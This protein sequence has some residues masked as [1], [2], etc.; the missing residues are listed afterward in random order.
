MSYQLSQE[1]EGDL[2]EIYDRSLDDWGEV[3]ADRYLEGLY[4][5]FASLEE[6]PHAGRQRPEAGEDVRS[7]L[8]GSHIV[9]YAF[10]SERVNILRILHQARDLGPAFSR[11]DG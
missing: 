6:R 11:Q 1:A 2:V 4:A 8:F 9:F 5:V 7:R 10:D 3:Q